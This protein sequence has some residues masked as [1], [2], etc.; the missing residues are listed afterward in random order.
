MPSRETLSLWFH[1]GFWENWAGQGK[2]KWRFPGFYRRLIEYK[3]WRHSYFWQD[4]F[5]IPWYRYVA[6]KIIGHGKTFITGDDGNGS[7]V[8]VCGKCLGY[9]D[10]DKVKRAPIENMPLYINDKDLT[11]QR[12]AIERLKTAR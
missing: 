1:F 2:R 5:I 8:L 9:P 3:L 7:E 10:R 6:C 12:I 11:V 4:S